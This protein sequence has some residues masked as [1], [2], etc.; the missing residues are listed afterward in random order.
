[1]NPPRRSRTWVWYFLILAV[2]AALSV[3]ILIRYN[4]GQQLTRQQ[5]DAARALWREKGPSDYD[6][7]YTKTTTATERFRVQVRRGKVV[8]ALRDGQPMEER[9]YIFYD[10]PGLFDALEGFLE[11]DARPGSSATYMVATFDPADGHLVRLV[12]R[13]MRTSERLEIRVTLTPVSAG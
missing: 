8:S 2:L 6:L 7:D 11:E 9:L 12:R 10:M 5:L 1:M 4:R 3:A 13:V